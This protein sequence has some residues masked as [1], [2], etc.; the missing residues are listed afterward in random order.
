MARQNFLILVLSIVLVVLIQGIAQAR[1][2][3][4][5][6]SFPGVNGSLSARNLL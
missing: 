5:V 1:Q 4:D 3:G 2:T 6:A